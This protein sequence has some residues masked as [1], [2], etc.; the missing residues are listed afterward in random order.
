MAL[1]KRALMDVE[2]PVGD[3]DGEVAERVGRDVDAAGKKTV[4]LHRGE[5]SIVPDDLGIGSDVVTWHP[6]L[7][8]RA[9]PAG[10][11]PPMGDAFRAPTCLG[12]FPNVGPAEAPAPRRR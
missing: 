10:S 9:K 8:R 3:A 1:E 12:S 11:S 7:P 6:P 5:G 4:A 2:V